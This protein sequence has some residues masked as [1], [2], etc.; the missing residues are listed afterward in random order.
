MRKFLFGAVSA[1][2]LTGAGF[3]VAAEA[4]ESPSNHPT[5][6]HNG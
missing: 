1:L 2:L 6:S 5:H 3:A 4:N